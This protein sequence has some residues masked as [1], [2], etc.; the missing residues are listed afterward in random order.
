MASG[1]IPQSNI[2]FSNLVLII[3]SV[4]NVINII[5]LSMKQSYERLML[6]GGLDTGSESQRL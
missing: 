3:I 6:I 1:N 4:N 2:F 5:I